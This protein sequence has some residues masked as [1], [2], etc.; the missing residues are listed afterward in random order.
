MSREDGE[1]GFS[2]GFQREATARAEAKRPL[3][4]NLEVCCYGGDDAIDAGDVLVVEWE[5]K[6]PALLRDATVKCVD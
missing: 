1:G 6:K 3:S 4:N 2:L 5:G